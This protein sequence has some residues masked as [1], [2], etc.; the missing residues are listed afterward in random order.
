[1]KFMED[2][3]GNRIEIGKAIADRAISL[4]INEP[5]FGNEVLIRLSPKQTKELISRLNEIVEEIT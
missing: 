2:L 3:Y 1:M 5:K 4:T